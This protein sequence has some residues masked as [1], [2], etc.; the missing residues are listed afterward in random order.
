MFKNKKGL[1]I[2]TSI[3]TVLPVL[4]GLL[5][6]D[7]L[8]EQLVIHWGFNGEPDGWSSRTQAVFQFPALMLGFHWLCLW[9]NEKDPRNK[10][11]SARIQSLVLWLCPILS[12][13]I[14]AAMYV[15]SLG[16]PFPLEKTVFILISVMFI[17]IGNYLPKC[18]QN[19][20]IG[21]K[22]L[23][24]LASEANWN[25][26]HR[27]GGRAWVAG[28]LLLLVGTFLP[29]QFFPWI[30]GA[31]LVLALVIPVVYSWRYSKKESD[32]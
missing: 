13:F 15:G 3:I 9:I 10:A 28:G 32:N 14:N 20:Y 31:T 22:L 11:Q 30:S 26:T 21:I 29:R 6:W 8:P 2:L 17:V 16:M 7:R 1:V 19:S 18:R 27:I 23:W 4:V 25:A 12:L 24:T 5:L